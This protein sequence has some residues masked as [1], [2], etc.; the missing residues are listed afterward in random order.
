MFKKLL[1]IGLILLVD[2][3]F[4]Q[5]EPIQIL[6]EKVANKLMLYALNETDIDYDVLITIEGTNFKQ[7]KG[8]PRLTRVPATSKVLINN[9]TLIKG[10]D[11]SYT[12]K[13]VINDSLSRRALIRE[14]EL[15]KVKPRK[16]I[17]VYI[18]ENCPD[19]DSIMKP[20]VNGKYQ[21]I[22][23]DLSQNPEIKSQIQMAVPTLD[24][25][26]TPIFSLQGLIYLWIKNYDELLEE[27]A[28]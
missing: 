16:Q 24:S 20:L 2:T 8:K 22:S 17:T 25:I 4:A 1:V 18:P 28:K 15:V 3:V 21:F 9:L 26:T 5:N 23:H 7:R 6:E 19:C 13:L 27:L 14:F 10:V 12:Y 11:P